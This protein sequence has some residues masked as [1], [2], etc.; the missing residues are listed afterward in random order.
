MTYIIDRPETVRVDYL[1]LLLVMTDYES[2]KE[3]CTKEICEVRA[4]EEKRLMQ[5]LNAEYKVVAFK[6]FCEYMREKWRSSG[7]EFGCHEWD[8]IFHS[9]KTILDAWGRL[10]HI[11]AVKVEWSVKATYHNHEAPRRRIPLGR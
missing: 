11:G 6:D 9:C 3:L 10:I 5:I 8:R 7:L 1:Q 2:G 4:D